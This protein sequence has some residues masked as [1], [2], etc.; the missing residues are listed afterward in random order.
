MVRLYLAAVL[1]M[2]VSG[3][4]PKPE[5]IFEAIK[6][7]PKGFFEAVEEA[8]NSFREVAQKEQE[9]K[10]M[11]ELEENFKNPLQPVLADN[12]AYW[13]PKEA[14]VT[15][16]E[17][18]DFECPYCSRGFQVVRELKEKYGDKVRVLYKHL[19]LENIHPNAMLAAKMFEAIAL[20]S[21]ELAYKF[22]DKLF[23][24]QRQLSGGE[25]YMTEVAKEL[26]VDMGRLKK[27]LASEEISKVI[28]ADVEEAGKFNITGTPG[29]IVNGVA[30]RGAL[31]ADMFSKV[32]DR[33]LAK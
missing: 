17:Y 13:G 2:M 8:Q 16:V 14:P 18:S 5:Q 11:E 33:H 23:E 21:A 30:L 19:P 32:I 12:R 20:Q 26:K 31:P 24:N 6:K 9:N 25:K 10:M 27:D 3:C 28:A 22:H 1:M 4:A 15:I 7:D 29:F